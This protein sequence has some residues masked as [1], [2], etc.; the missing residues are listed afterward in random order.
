MMLRKPFIKAFWLCFI[1]ICG[2]FIVTHLTGCAE[3]RFASDLAS[4]V[5][6]PRDCN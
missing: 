4:C 1:A 2:V 3:A 5:T 6:H